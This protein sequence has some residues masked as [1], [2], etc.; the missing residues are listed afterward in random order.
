MKKKLT[1]NVPLKI[2]SVAVAVVLWLL[3]VNIDNPIITKYIT[4][5]EVN[6]LN[7]AYIESDNKISMINDEEINH[8]K[9]TVRITGKRKTVD[10]L[11]AE[12]I[13]ANADL[14]QIVSMNTSPI[15]VP[16]DVSCPGI[17]P[18][19]ITA[20]PRTISINIE[21]MMSKDFV[22][23]V[24][25]DN[26][27]PGKGYEIGTLTADPVKVT[28]TGPESTIKKIDKV[29]APLE[30]DGITEDTTQKVK[31]K[32]ID[33]NQSELSDNEMNSLKYSEITDG[34]VNVT[35]TLWKIKSNIRVEAQYAG[36]PAD[37][38]K[39][40]KLTVTPE[41]I[42]VA[43]SDDALSLLAAN[44]NLIQIPA[45]AI[46]VS[47]K[48][49]DFETNVNIAKLLPEDV[50]LTSESNESVIVRANILPLNS[51]EYQISTKQITAKN[52][53]KD[54]NLV[55]EI[56]K[57]DVQVQGT[58]EDIEQLTESSIQASIDLSGKKSGTWD[59]PVTVKL[60]DGYELISPVTVGIKLSETAEVSEAAAED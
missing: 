56:E 45:E 50:I 12:D 14:Q 24:P 32:I 15:M 6:I 11:T 36:T 8:G 3:V 25:K 34:M 57:I 41:E 13:T 53:P 28:I 46:D 59:V 17:A 47:G 51:K 60:P 33:K 38:Y 7:E 49:A 26:A 9:I 55:Y 44:G 54:L 16:I 31:L 23:S 58:T 20:V 42:S 29:V 39:V 5:V 2:M 37:G 27:K 48:N 43:G 10:K 35:A 22:I 52:I 1:S 30:A 21:N 40:E 4:G 19:N 18:A